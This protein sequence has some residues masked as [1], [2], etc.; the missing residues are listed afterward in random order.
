MKEKD[1]VS[2]SRRKKFVEL[3]HRLDAAVLRWDAAGRGSE[4]RRQ[5][6]GEI[7]QIQAFLRLVLLQRT[8]WR[9]SLSLVFRQLHLCATS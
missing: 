3:G 4:E 2:E 5:S 7:L 9:Q 6:E 8:N 1:T